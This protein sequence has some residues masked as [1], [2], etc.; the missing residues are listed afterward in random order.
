MGAETSETVRLEFT[1]WSIA[2]AIGIL[3]AAAVVVVLA[4]ASAEVL[5]WLAIATV[6][7]ATVYPVVRR[8]KQRVPA[9]LALIVVFGAL[10]AISGALGYRGVAEA[11]NQQTVWRD[12]AVNTARDLEGSPRFG[13][14][15][16]E[17][18]LVDKVGAGFAALP[19][20]GADMGAALQVAA[21]DASALFAVFTLSLLMVIFGPAFVAGGLGQVRDP[22]VRGRLR[23]HVRAA[24]ERCWRYAWTMAA[25]ALA[26]GA[27]TALVAT[28]IGA[29]SPTVIAVWF[30]A[31][32]LIPGIGL[33][34]AAIPFVLIETMQ[35]PVLAV[36]LLIVVLLVQGFDAVVVQ[37]RIHRRAVNIGA[38]PT[39]LAFMIGYQLDGFGGAL[40]VL[41]VVGF[42]LAFL[43][44]LT[45][46][47]HD[48]ADASSTL[49]SSDTKAERRGHLPPAGVVRVAADGSAGRHFDLGW[50]SVAAAA[51]LVILLLVL[52]AVATTGPV[53]VL[54]AVGLLFTFAL[55]PLVGRVQR[56]LHLPRGFAVAAC[57]C[58]VAA[59]LVGGIVGLAPST[60]EQARSFQQDLPHVVDDLTQL[61]V[62]GSTLETSDTPAKVRDFV[63]RVPQEAGRDPSSIVT[64][65]S[66]AGSALLFALIVML[67]IVTML[68]DGPRLVG[69]LKLVP[70]RRHL[71]LATRAGALLSE[72]VGRYFSGSLL[73]AGLQALQVL[74]TGF[75]LGVPLTPLLAVWA[76]VWNLVPQVGG[77]VGGVLFVA[78]AFTQGAT[79][80]IIAAVAF[81]VYLVIANNVLHPVIIGHAVDLSP[82]TTMIATIAGFAVGGVIGAILGVPVLGACKAIY[83]E[84]RPSERP[85]DR[86]SPRRRPPGRV[87]ATTERVR[88]RAAGPPRRVPVSSD[89]A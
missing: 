81:G 19:G 63:A 22:G 12:H 41:A 24:Y 69:L 9:A 78:V 33:V 75:A 30:A 8:L 51:G 67:I 25:R 49:M 89:A 18:G 82:V 21:T 39:L 15:A 80:G 79:A 6:V 17:F 36:V 14:A 73:L 56:G 88:T 50:R 84:L 16:T 3:A 85:A 35:S 58:L 74:V 54:A 11:T 26:V 42:A 61:P 45:D 46:D 34:L 83:A 52:I 59:V 48:L 44:S 23:R 86:R 65:A 32:S 31:F 29:E 28:V 47:A 27:I 7:A 62:V 71:D 1:T 38:A 55:D 64:V 77:A 37:R 10:L 53:V 43:A 70:P 13:Q 4:R 2:R 20:S 5:W 87:R 66:T 76:G 60:V 57:C 40:V 72:S 68:I